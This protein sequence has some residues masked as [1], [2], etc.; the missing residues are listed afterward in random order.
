MVGP[1]TAGTNAAG[2]SAHLSGVTPPCLTS[3]GYRA[4]VTGTAIASVT[5]ALDGRRIVKVSRPNARGAF[6]T[7]VAL[8]AGRAH[9]L[10]MTVDFTKAGSSAP[11]TL[12]RTLALCYPKIKTEKSK[13]EAVAPSFTG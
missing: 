11:T 5:F 9:M 3:N 7:W 12:Q 13:S 1:L 2:A 6:T 10:R 4:S 8:S